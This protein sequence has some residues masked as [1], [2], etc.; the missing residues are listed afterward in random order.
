ML[1]PNSCAHDSD[2]RTFMTVRCF[3]RKKIARV[4]PTRKRSRALGA[5]E[6]APSQKTSRG[7]KSQFQVLRTLAFK[8]IPLIWEEG[9]GN[10]M[11]TNGPY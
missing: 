1:R 9:I 8:S 2:R 4:K 11:K 10:K 5:P 3:R 7:L 6:A